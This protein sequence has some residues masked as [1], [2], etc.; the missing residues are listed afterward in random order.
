MTEDI[1][2]TIN[3]GFKAEDF[4]DTLKTTHVLI[5]CEDTMEH[6]HQKD[7]A[8]YEKNS[9]VELTRPKEEHEEHETIHSGKDLEKGRN[10]KD[11]SAK[12]ADSN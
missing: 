10:E 7:M 8:N 9:R 12:G 5:V 1:S 3:T 4:A 2:N 11:E 6:C